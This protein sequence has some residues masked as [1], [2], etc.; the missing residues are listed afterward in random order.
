MAE[1]GPAPVERIIN[2]RPRLLSYLRR[3]GLSPE[4]AEDVAQEVIIHA[5][6]RYR[7][8]DDPEKLS[9]WVSGIVRNR[10]LNTTEQWSRR[11]AVEFSLE[12]LMEARADDSTAWIEDAAPGPEA[13]AIWSAELSRVLEDIG[14]LR[15]E[16]R[17]VIMAIVDGGDS[18][19]RI[20][21]R[22]GYAEVSIRTMRSKAR[23]KLQLPPEEA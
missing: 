10:L 12:A 20:A 9:E 15:P 18:D 22:R 14:R 19:R 2:M 4:D 1:A 16:E 13:Q 23:R 8:L 17:E 3:H 5:V 21:A 7:Q 11:I 6:L